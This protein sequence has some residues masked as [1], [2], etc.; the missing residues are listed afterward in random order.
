MIDLSKIPPLPGVYIIKDRYSKIIYIG[1]AKNLRKRVKSYFSKSADLN[2]KTRN[3][4]LFAFSIDF[5]ICDSEREA[6]IVERKLI[7]VNKPV[8]NV[9]WKD[10]KTY[11]YVVL[12]DEDFPRLVVTRKGNLKG[13]YF[14][15]YPHSDII[16][17]LIERLSDIKFIN[18]RKCNYEFSVENPLPESKKQK[19]IYYHTMQ[20]PAPCDANRITRKDYMKLVNRVK[21]FFLMRHL[22]L[23]R[24]FDKKMKQHSDRLEFEKA[25][26]YR[27]FI[28]A[29]NHIYERVSVNERDIKDIEK[30]FNFTELLLDIK[31]K[32]ALK[33]IPYHIESFDVSNLFNKYIVGVCVCYIN[34]FKNHSHYRRFKS[35][36]ES[37][38]NSG[39][40]FQVIYEIVKR[41]YDDEK[42]IPDLIIVDGGKGQL[43]SALKALREAGINRSDLIA[44][45]KEEEKI[46]TLNSDEAIILKKDS[47]ELVFITAVRDETHR[48]AITYHR[49]LRDSNFLV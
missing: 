27:D 47:P 42:D 1:K 44:I 7:S 17:R 6:L 5:I 2:F 10:S 16:K 11:P 41:R 40:D 28:N 30:K 12:T 43:N 48:F 32:L 13:S 18:L 38:K 49:K 14:G 35:R 19:C 36:L 20:C 3:I 37:F 33:N 31:E 4:K 21:K 39:D 25:K 8:F 15:P 46:Y 34:G 9:M 22:S 23:I 24:E 29:I 45:A 26:E